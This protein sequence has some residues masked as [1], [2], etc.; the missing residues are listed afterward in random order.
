[1]KYFGD[2]NIEHGGSFVDGDFIFSVSPGE[3]DY[4]EE[5]AEYFF[6]EGYLA[7]DY[8]PF[9]DSDYYKTDIVILDTEEDLEE[10]LL[11]KIPEWCRTIYLEGV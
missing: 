4:F 5:T 11:S 8:E 2:V 3:I 9:G 1:M 10:Q 6:S 7:D